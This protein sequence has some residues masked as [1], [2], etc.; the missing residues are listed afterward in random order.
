MLIVRYLKLGPDG[1]A[2]AL[3]IPRE[4]DFEAYQARLEAT[5]YVVL[6]AHLKSVPRPRVSPDAR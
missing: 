4:A 3:F 2:G 6:G 1:H 5:G